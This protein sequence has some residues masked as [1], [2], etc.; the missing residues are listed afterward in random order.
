MGVIKLKE[1]RSVVTLNEIQTNWFRRLQN[2]LVVQL[3]NE[4]MANRLRDSNVATDRYILGIYIAKAE[5]AMNLYAEMTK[6]LVSLMNIS[7]TA[8][9]F[10]TPYPS[11][12]IDCSREYLETQDLVEQIFNSKSN[13][14]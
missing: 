8:K 11:N 9:A 2:L 12:G 1:V 13:E 4:G 7:M 10:Y 5:R 14:D 3:E 6:R